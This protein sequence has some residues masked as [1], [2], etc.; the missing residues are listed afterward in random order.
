VVLYL[1]NCVLFNSFLVYSTLNTNKKVKYKNFLHKVGRS[2]K[3]EVQNRRESSSDDLQLPEKFCFQLL[4]SPTDLS[5]HLNYILWL[6]TSSSILVLISAFWTTFTYSEIQ[7]VY[8]SSTVSQS[9]FFSLAISSCGFCNNTD[10]RQWDAK[11]HD[12]SALWR[13]RHWP[14]T[15]ICVV[16]RMCSCLPQLYCCYL[17]A[18]AVFVIMGSVTD[19]LTDYWR[20]CMLHIVNFCSPW[21]FMRSMKIIVRKVLFFRLRHEWSYVCTRT[22]YSVTLKL[23]T[24][25]VKPVYCAQSTS[26]TVLFPRHFKRFLKP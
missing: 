4:P 9:Q 22:C 18:I 21:P 19:W 3:S 20:G 1:L 15:H 24:I 7:L 8:S 16:G 23:K 2:W 5:Y 10:L 14:L 12:W 6:F 25:L 26:P 13:P 11:C 17:V